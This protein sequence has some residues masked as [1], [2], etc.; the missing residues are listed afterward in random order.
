MTTSYDSTARVFDFS[1]KELLSIMGHNSILWTCDI[2]SDNSM[3]LTGGADCKVK[4]WD[5]SGKCI[6]TLSGHDFDVYCAKFSPDNSL[7]LTSGGDNTARLWTKEGVLKKIFEIN[8]D[9]R[10]SMSII[11][12]AVFSND[13]Q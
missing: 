3:F 2:S 8:E 7:I 5:L 6:S 4:V 10:F 9:N 1:G 12:S 13:G 11:V